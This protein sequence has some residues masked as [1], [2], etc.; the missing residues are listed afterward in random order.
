MESRFTGPVALL[1]PLPLHD[2]QGQP[3]FAPPSNV[4]S[5]MALTNPGTFGGVFVN[6]FSP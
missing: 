1:L 5:V 4:A 6:Q 2:V 3:G